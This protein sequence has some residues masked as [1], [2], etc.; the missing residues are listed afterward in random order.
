MPEGLELLRSAGPWDQHGVPEGLR[1]SHRI[2]AGVWGL[3]EV[4]DGRVGFRM[5]TE[6]LLDTV[7]DNGTS[8]P[9]PPAVAHAVRIIGPVQIRVQFW[10]HRR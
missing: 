9:I 1:R 3:L 8:Q 6:P 10:G 7:L 2:A 5:E 4:L